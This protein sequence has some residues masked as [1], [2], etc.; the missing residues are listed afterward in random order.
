MSYELCIRAT[1][2]NF[3]TDTLL[4]YTL[5]QVISKST[6]HKN[7]DRTNWKK[8]DLR[9]GGVSN[10]FMSTFGGIRTEKGYSMQVCTNYGTCLSCAWMLNIQCH[11]LHVNIIRDPYNCPYPEWFPG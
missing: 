10:S 7:T 2:I 6:R 4:C 8:A 9:S 5:C 3:I 11:M 1:I